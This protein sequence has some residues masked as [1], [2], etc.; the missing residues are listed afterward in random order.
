MKNLLFAIFLFLAA[1]SHA[2]AH[3]TWVQVPS[4]VTRQKD[5]VHIDLMV[6]NHGNEH[7]DFKLAS[8]ITLAPCTLELVAPNGQRIDLKEKVTDMGS[9]EKEG[10]WSARHV[11][12][13]SGVYQV[14]HTLDTLHGK[15]RAIKSSK[16][17]FI[18]S[19]DLGSIPT[20][21]AERIHPLNSGLEFVLEDPIETLAA[22]REIHVQLLWNGK[23]LPN[24]LVAFVPRGAKLSESPDPQFEKLTDAQGRVAFKPTEGNLLL[25]VAHH[26]ANDE[27][28]EGFDK[29]SYGATMVLPVPQIPF[30]E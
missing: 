27:S 6:G 25:I 10:F 18:A 12:D 1:T 9:A 7:R 23:P 30:K 20:T 13:Q 26:T 2:L 17:F 28:G 15:T 3:D 5:V 19:K 16:T 29:T 24:T 11:V 14:L 21:G 4:L 8:K 22:L